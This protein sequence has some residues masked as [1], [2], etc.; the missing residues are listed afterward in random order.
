MTLV[1]A[2]VKFR[3]QALKT[4]GVIDNFSIFVCDF[5]FEFGSNLKR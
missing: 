2:H 4:K 1:H 5:A 3:G